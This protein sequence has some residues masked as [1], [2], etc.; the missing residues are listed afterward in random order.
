MS[1]EL[2]YGQAHKF[3]R[4][5]RRRGNDVRWEGWDILFW[6]PNPYGFKQQ[7]GEFRNGRWGVG[8]RVT[9]DND[10]KWRVSLSNVKSFRGTRS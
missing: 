6:K 2:N 1:L 4:D 8:T 7:T 9:V 10:G 3:V 5:Q